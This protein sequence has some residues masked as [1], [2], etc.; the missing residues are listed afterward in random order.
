MLSRGLKECPNSGQLWA[1]AIELEPRNTRKKKIVEAVK[2]IS[3]D[4]YINLAIAKT[5][6]KEKK[7]E[8]AERWLEKAI[9]IDPNIGDN[10]ACYYVFESEKEN[11]S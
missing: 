3:D 2:L 8:K 9:Q 4:P 10:W 5:F 6:W 1:L 7:L 11:N